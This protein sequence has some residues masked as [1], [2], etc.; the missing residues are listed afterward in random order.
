M[1]HLRR[2][3]HPTPQPFPLFAL[4]V[5]PLPGLRGWRGGSLCR[6]ARMTPAPTIHTTI[7]PL[8]STSGVPMP[9]FVLAACLFLSLLLATAPAAADKESDLALNLDAWKGPLKDWMQADSV[10]LDP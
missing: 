3:T 9:R 7:R 1:P 4:L 10:S 6:F 8:P 2:N 5:P